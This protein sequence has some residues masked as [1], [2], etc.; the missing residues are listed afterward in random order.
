[1]GFPL[2]VFGTYAPEDDVSVLV[3]LDVTDAIAAPLLEKNGNFLACATSRDGEA[4]VLSSWLHPEQAGQPILLR[5]N[6]PSSHVV[7]PFLLARGPT[8]AVM[9]T[10]WFWT[11]SFVWFQ[12]CA[13]I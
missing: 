13:V 7:L 1:M 10:D 4:K 5:L 6:V 11:G 2:T 9:H 3:H 12:T 8:R